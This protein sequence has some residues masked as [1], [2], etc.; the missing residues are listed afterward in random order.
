MPDLRKKFG[1]DARAFRWREL[2]SGRFVAE[3]SVARAVRAK[4]DAGARRFREMA[5]A[6]ARRS[7][8]VSLWR[9]Q[10]IAEIKYQHT[11]AVA[12]AWG[13]WRQVPQEAW[14]RAGRRLRQ[15]YRY[16]D[17]LGRLV[18]LGLIDPN[19]AGFV[20]RS[21]SY[22]GQARIRYAEERRLALEASG[23]EAVAVWHLG[24][25]ITDHCEGC[26]DEA[27]RTKDGVLAEDIAEIGSQQCLWFCQCWIELKPAPREQNSE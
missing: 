21:V 13:G 16:L 23:V 9:D 14:L 19:S 22:G 10:M 24:D 7:T 6:L 5:R 15:E 20:A 2:S 3:R 18:D 27:E 11:S 12:A 1:W 17:R 25:V 4:S 8:T 26:A